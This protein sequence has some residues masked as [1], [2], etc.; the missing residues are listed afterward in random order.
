MFS[1][2]HQWRTMIT[3]AVKTKVRLK[4]LILARAKFPF[5]STSDLLYC[6][7]IASDEITKDALLQTKKV[8]ICLS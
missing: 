1:M 5:T 2:K 6:S 7:R 4:R 8:V 3:N